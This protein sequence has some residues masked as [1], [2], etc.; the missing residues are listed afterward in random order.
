MSKKIIALI[1][2]YFEDL[3]DSF[4][5]LE[6]SLGGVNEDIQ[7]EMDKDDVTLDLTRWT[8]IK[9]FEANIN[10]IDIKYAVFD[11]NNEY[12][13]VFLMVDKGQGFEKIPLDKRSDTYRIN[14][15]RSDTEYKIM[16]GYQ[17]AKIYDETQSDNIIDNFKIK[18]INIDYDIDIYKI[19][20][21]RVYYEVDFKDDLLPNE[22]RISLKVDGVL[23]TE[24]IFLSKVIDDNKYRGYFEVNDFGYTMSVCLDDIVIGGNDVDFS[25][26]ATIKN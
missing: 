13:E 8:M 11:P 2:E 21:N 24:N 20:G 15:L 22:F 23:L 18:T 5:N 4:N 9:S 26:Y 19:S 1:D 16:F 25:T 6:S 12:A 3:K 14:N 7:D 17:L 10:S